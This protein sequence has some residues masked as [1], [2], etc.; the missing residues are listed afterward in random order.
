MRLR[1]SVLLH[2]HLYIPTPTLQHKQF[3]IPNLGL[4]IRYPISSYLVEQCVQHAGAEGTTGH[5]LGH[6]EVG[7]VVASARLG[8]GKG[9]SYAQRTT[10]LP[11]VS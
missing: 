3:H 10:I 4:Q 2:M 6:E 8:E 9:R 7:E 5:K 11:V 1:E